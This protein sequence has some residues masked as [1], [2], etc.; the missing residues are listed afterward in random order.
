MRDRSGRSA[1]RR[2]GGSARLT[3]N[4]LAPPLH[5]I[6]G[7]TRVSRGPGTTNGD[8]QRSL[9]HQLEWFGWCAHGEVE[10]MTADSK[11]DPMTEM[12]GR[13]VDRRRLLQG[14]AALGMSVPALSGAMAIPG[15]AYFA[16]AQDASDGIMTISQEQ[17]QTWVRNFNP[18]LPESQGC[19]WPTHSGIYEPLFLYSLASAEITPWLAKEWAFNADNTVLTFTLQEGVTWSDG[20]P[21]TAKD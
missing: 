14:A 7:T 18:F 3:P 12:T 13:R 17:Q 19:R 9:R 15:R 21:F 4:G 2:G 16:S 11:R 10:K 6:H 5:A 20:T 1:S 8:R